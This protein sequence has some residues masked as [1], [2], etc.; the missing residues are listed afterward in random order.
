[1]DN[2]IVNNLLPDMGTECYCFNLNKKEV[3]G[4]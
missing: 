2:E 1:M 3:I 4:S